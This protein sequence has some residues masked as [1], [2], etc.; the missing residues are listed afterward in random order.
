MPILKLGLTGG[1]A[2]GKSFV[3]AELQR[4]GASVIHADQLGHEALLR[5]GP[6]YIPTVEFFGRHILS[7]TGEIDRTLLARKVFTDP[8]AL[9]ILNGFV[10]PAVF[11]REDE[12]F[13]AAPSGTLVVVE[14]A[15]LIETG[16]YRKLDKLAVVYCSPEQQIQRALQRPGAT[17]Q[18]VEARLSRQLPLSEKLR[19]A[20]YTIDTSGTEL[21]T[22][23]QTRALF[24]TLKEDLHQLC[25][26][27]PSS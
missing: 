17:R 8:A 12:L 10:H 9:E 19:F 14:A 11:A 15:I 5:S 23:R 25:D 1:L 22:L 18:D 26:S 27:A 2:S 13:A 16:S 21:A 20:D 6:A 7:H 4:L 3:A 24:A